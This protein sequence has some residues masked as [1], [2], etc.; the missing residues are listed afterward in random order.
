MGVYST[1]DAAIRRKELEE[2]RAEEAGFG[3]CN[4]FR[5]ESWAVQ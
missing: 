1:K 5:V 3:D 2:R 4:K